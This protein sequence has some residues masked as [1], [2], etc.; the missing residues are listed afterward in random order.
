MNEIPKVKPGDP[1]KAATFNRIIDVANARAGLDSL[2]ESE[3]LWAG[4]ASGA[5]SALSGTTPGAGT[6]RAWVYSDSTLVDSGVDYDV[7]NASDAISDGTWCTIGQDG[8]GWWWVVTGK[9]GGDSIFQAQAPSSGTIAATGTF[10]TTPDS[11]TSDVY[12]L[13]G[14]PSSVDTGA[15]IY[16]HSTTAI[17]ASAVVIVKSNGNGSY[18]VINVVC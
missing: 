7:L 16:Y 8:N 2:T 18:S 11:F 4:K 15:T 1:V 12:T 9:G 14:T 6:V 17:T 5:I 10:P 3:I 13:D